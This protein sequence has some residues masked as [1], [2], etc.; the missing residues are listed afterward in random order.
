VSFTVDCTYRTRG[1]MMTMENPDEEQ[2]C[3]IMM[4]SWTQDALHM[5]LTAFRLT[6]SGETDE[7]ERIDMS[8]FSMNSPWIVTSQEERSIFTKKYDCCP[9]PYNHIDFRFKVRRAF[10][11]KDGKKIYDLEPYKIQE[12]IRAQAGNEEDSVFE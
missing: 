7:N 1:E 10:H 4:G 11:I 9:E 5:N 6:L 12:H 8:D 2:D 3:H